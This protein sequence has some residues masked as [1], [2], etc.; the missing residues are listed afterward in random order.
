MTAGY[1]HPDPSIELAAKTA[2]T[3]LHR[4]FDGTFGPETIERC[5]LLEDMDVTVNA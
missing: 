3:N 5:A 4:R 2:A 1:R